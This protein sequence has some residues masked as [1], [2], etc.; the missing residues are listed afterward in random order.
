MCG[1][2]YIQANGLS[3]HMLKHEGI[4]PYQCKKCFGTFKYHRSMTLHM[5]TCT[6]GNGKFPLELGNSVQTDAIFSPTSKEKTL[7]VANASLPEH[8]DL[9]QYRL[10]VHNGASHDNTVRVELPV[11]IYQNMVHKNASVPMCSGREHCAT[12]V[13]NLYN[14]K[15]ERY[16][17]QQPIVQQSLSYGGGNHQQ[18]FQHP[19]TL[20]EN[21]SG[22]YRRPQPHNYSVNYNNAVSSFRFSSMST[23]APPDQILQNELHLNKYQKG[24]IAHPTVAQNALPTQSYNVY[25]PMQSVHQQAYTSSPMIKMNPAMTQHTA[26]NYSNSQTGDLTVNR[27]EPRMPLFEKYNTPNEMTLINSPMFPPRHISPSVHPIG[28]Q[29]QQPSPRMLQMVSPNIGSTN[30]DVINDYRP[31]TNVAYRKQNTGPLSEN[32]FLKRR[33]QI[34]QQR[35]LTPEKI[36]QYE[37]SH[38]NIS[39]TMHDTTTRLP[40]QN[41]RN[42]NGNH[43]YNHWT[44]RKQPSHAIGAVLISNPS[45]IIIEGPRSLNQMAN[46]R[47]GPSTLKTENQHAHSICTYY[48]EK[49][50]ERRMEQ[51][52]KFSCKP[53]PRGSKME[54]EALDLTAKINVDLQEINRVDTPLD[55]RCST[56]NMNDKIKSKSHLHSM[57]G[58]HSMLNTPN[59]NSAPNDASKYYKGNFITTN[60]CENLV[61]K[62][63]LRQPLS[64]A[65]PPET[66][67][68]GHCTI[69]NCKLCLT[70]LKIPFPNLVTRS[71]ESTRLVYPSL[72]EQQ[73]DCNFGKADRNENLHKYD[74]GNPIN[75]KDYR[76]DKRKVKYV[77][78]DH[79]NTITNENIASDTV[80]Y[81]KS[82]KRRR[83][84]NS[85]SNNTVITDVKQMGINAMIDL[86]NKDK[87]NIKH[88]LLNESPSTGSVSKHKLYDVDSTVIDMSVKKYPLKT[89]GV[90]GAHYDSG[91]HLKM[92]IENVRFK[93]SEKDEEDIINTPRYCSVTTLGD[94]SACNNTTADVKSL[95]K[96]PNG[97]QMRYNNISDNKISKDNVQFL[98]SYDTKCVPDVACDV[99]LDNGDYE[100]KKK[101]LGELGLITTVQ[102][103]NIKSPSIHKSSVTYSQTVCEQN[104]IIE[105][106]PKNYNGI[107]ICDKL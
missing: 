54:V 17:V 65:I 48:P 31:Y 86:G 6:G 91:N 102:S 9:Y 107:L 76:A 66:M 4:E 103:G 46:T 47:G 8:N 57:K 37:T 63:V 23:L 70:D 81:S 12:S 89:N 87:N 79:T 21:L 69:T 88:I 85:E 45:G 52:L 75:Y 26:A 104:Y 34:L 55:L 98:N 18:R 90:D 2:S 68:S 96:N 3:S 72:S 83:L 94:R 97:N 78:T 61:T 16:P 106:L 53:E 13:P 38:S 56:Q 82:F 5:Q 44:Q 22:C 58:S 27:L 35:E 71:T 101:M 80:K 51:S 15:D 28:S 64:P 43:A 20:S 42:V 19:V 10:R 59:T 39:V 14:I 67:R 93:C 11:T 25:K 74:K 29:Q 30:H 24:N 36:N 73:T 95:C 60:Y 32:E 1:E 41:M 33:Q 50:D 7:D 99:N 84:S 92:F 40:P 100:E 77:E 49:D 105:N 62:H